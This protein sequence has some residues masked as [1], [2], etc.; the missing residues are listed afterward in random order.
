MSK[1]WS[2]VLCIMDMNHGYLILNCM[3][4][5]FFSEI[6]V[7]IIKNLNVQKGFIIEIVNIIKENMIYRRVKKW[8]KLSL[9]NNVENLWVK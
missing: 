7:W 2:D 8:Y 3:S 1:I 4:I 5:Y 9:G 6:Y